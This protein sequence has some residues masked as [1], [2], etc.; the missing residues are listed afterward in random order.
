MAPDQPKESVTAGPVE[1]RTVDALLIPESGTESGGVAMI[2]IDRAGSGRLGF[3]WLVTASLVISTLSVVNAPGASAAQSVQLSPEIASTPVP[4][5][6][7]VFFDKT[8][9]VS[10]TGGALILSADPGGTG[11]VITDDELRLEVTD[12]RGTRR[13]LVRNYSN[14]CT[15][16][17][18]QGPAD[19]ASLFRGG[20]NRVRVRLRDTCGT[21]EG[22]T[23]YWLAGKVAV[24][25]AS[26]ESQFGNRR[27][28]GRAEDPVNTAT[29][30]FFHTEVD[31]VFPDQVYGLG[32]E[33]TYNAQDDSD[34]GL[35]RGWS[36][37]FGASVTEGDDG[38]VILRDA[39]GRLIEFVPQDGGYSRPEE[40]AGELVKNP[41]GTFK[42]AYF[43]GE[44]WS[45]DST[46][47]LG[48]KSNWDGQSV[49]FSYGPDGVLAS[50]A[51][52]TGRSIAFSTTDGRITTAASSDGRRVTYAYDGSGRLEATTAPD[53]G[54]TRYT[55]DAEG[56]ITRIVDPRGSRCSTTPTTTPGE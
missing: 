3:V 17:S 7:H 29:G 24:V 31:L 4:S 30:N 26:R 52:S 33:R 16:P 40:F 49:A 19:V 48:T 25:A 41:D 50:A 14:G 9:K 12:A 2:G 27:N 18:S 37:N 20:T 28:A 8:I 47:R 5:V 10:Y 44:T 45:F 11:D 15:T 55:S 42:A 56:R 35:G 32:L 23:A 38:V 51:H 21:A 13:T 6:G 46:G 53:G 22:S 1:P 39:D 34:A 43:G 36:H 54:V